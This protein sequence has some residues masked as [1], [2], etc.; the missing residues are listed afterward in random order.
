MDMY[1]KICERQRDNSTN[2]KYS[3]RKNIC[4]VV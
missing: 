3:R 4:V 2:Y 1:F